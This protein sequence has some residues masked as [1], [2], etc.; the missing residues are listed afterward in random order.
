VRR[1]EIHPEAEEEFAQAAFYLDAERVGYG[2]VFADRVRDAY[3]IVMT[4]PRAGKLVGR[5]ARRIEVSGFRYAVIYQILP[6]LI[7]ILAIAHHSRRPGFW[8][9]RLR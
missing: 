5:R 9:S 7:F 4:Y 6:D 8:R 1:V 3:E 2:D